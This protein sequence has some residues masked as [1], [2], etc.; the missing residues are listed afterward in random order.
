MRD[1]LHWRKMT[2]TILIAVMLGAVWFV[3]SGY[4][5]F[6]LGVSLGTVGLLWL[7]WYFTEP[8]WRQGHGAHVQRRHAPAVRFKP[9]K[10]LVEP[11][12][13]HNGR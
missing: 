3:L 1:F 4:S 9:V 11:R 7:L 10:S 8:L 6:I 5:F 2:W 12:P 13:G